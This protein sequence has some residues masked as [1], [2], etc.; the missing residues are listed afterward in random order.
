MQTTPKNRAFASRTMNADQIPECRA[1]RPSQVR[2]GGRRAPPL[3]LG[4]SQVGRP[5]PAL[6]TVT[7][8]EEV[9]MR[10][11]EWKARSARPESPPTRAYARRIEPQGALGQDTAAERLATPTRD[12][13]SVKL[14]VPG[15]C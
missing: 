6:P 9:G 8:T 10:A 4:R 7:V 1:L 12:D 2:M 15:G 11:R 5:R 14:K 13:C 3:R